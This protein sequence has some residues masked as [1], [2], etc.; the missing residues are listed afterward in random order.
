LEKGN[1]TRSRQGREGHHIFVIFLKDMKIKEETQ[2]SLLTCD[3]YSEGNMCD[4]LILQDGEN[5]L[6]KTD[7]L[8]MYP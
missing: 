2:D 5:G 7:K 3:I 8:G 4:H 1:K 6:S